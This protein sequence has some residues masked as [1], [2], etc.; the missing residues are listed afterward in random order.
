MPFAAALSTNSDTAGAVAEVCTGALQS[1]GL[2]G[3]PPQLALLFF[4]PHHVGSLPRAVGDLLQRL[5]TGTL[6]GCSGEAII[7]NDREVEQGP[8][9]CLWL[10]RWTKP[11]TVEPFHLTFGQDATGVNITGMPD[12]IAAVDPQRSAI[13]LL[14]EPSS[15]RADLFLAPINETFPGLPVIG[16]L[17]TGGRAS[18]QGRLLQGD[19][20]PGQG[21]VGVLISSESDVRGIVSHG[22]RPLGQ[23]LVI[24]RARGNI[25]LELEGKPP[26]AHLQSLY[27][28]LG[29][30]EQQL[31]QRGLHIGLAPTRDRNPL[32]IYDSLARNIIGRDRSTGSLTIDG[33]LSAGQ[34]VQFLVR[35]PASADAN[36]HGILQ[37]ERRERGC[38]PAAALLFGCNCRGASFFSQPDHDARVLRAELGHVPVA[39]MSTPGEIGPVSGR[40]HLHAYTASIALFSE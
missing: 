26:L 19:Q 25:L 17:A 23:P 13:L 33:P 11:T 9:L 18:S 21:A 32:P 14:A 16:G 1:L 5:G 6:I 35:D 8:A 38:N 10:A 36:L 20:M 7:G 28:Q 24:H 27:S 15:F 37:R 12:A 40:N 22:C 34:T 29:L 3:G 30:R 4:S 39:G 2:D 31:F